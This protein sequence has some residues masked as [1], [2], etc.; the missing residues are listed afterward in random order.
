MLLN[1]DLAQAYMVH[2][3]FSLIKIK[4]EKTVRH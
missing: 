1:I 2:T 3:K 4:Y